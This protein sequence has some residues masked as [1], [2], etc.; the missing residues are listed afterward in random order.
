MKNKAKRTI[1]HQII[2]WLL[3]LILI[4]SGAIIVW[5]LL[6]ITTFSSFKLPTG[7][8]EPTI[9]PGNYI[10][11]NKWLIGARIFDAWESAEG[12][13]VEISR[14]P[15]IRNIKRNDVMVFNDPYYRSSALFMFQPREMK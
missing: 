13:E 7:S 9:L 8:M 1:F 5:L 4:A 14:L 3:N 11:V 2:D 10:L 12:K 6:I 15:G